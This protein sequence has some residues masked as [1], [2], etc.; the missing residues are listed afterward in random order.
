MHARMHAALRSR[1]GAGP[2]AVCVRACVRACVWV[3]V[4]VCVCVCVCVCVRAA[5]REVNECALGAAASD[6]RWTGRAF[7]HL[8]VA[9]H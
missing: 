6:I 4:S 5:C 7:R 2:S 1:G 9:M 8:N 3:C